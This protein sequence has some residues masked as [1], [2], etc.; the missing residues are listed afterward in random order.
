MNTKCHFIFYEAPICLI[1]N[2]LYKIGKSGY[3]LFKWSKVEQLSP[4]ERR[5]DRGNHCRWLS[6]LEQLFPYWEKRRKLPWRSLQ[7]AVSCWNSSLTGRTKRR[8]SR[9]SLQMA[10]PCWN[11]L[12]QEDIGGRKRKFPEKRKRKTGKGV[13]HFRDR[14]NLSTMCSSGQEWLWLILPHKG[15]KVLNYSINENGGFIF[16]F[17]C[18]SR[19]AIESAWCIF[20]AALQ[21]YMRSCPT[22]M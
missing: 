11:W 9:R 8:W 3:I 10:G 20:L 12:F 22:Q 16:P 2:I 19:A 7:M 14:C 17:L 15:G 13:S 1:W 4:T 5:N 21:P 6:I 18:R